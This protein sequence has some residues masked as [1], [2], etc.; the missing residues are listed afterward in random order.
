MKFKKLLCTAFLALLWCATSA[1]AY[2]PEDVEF[3]KKQAF[4]RTPVVRGVPNGTLEARRQY[5]TQTRNHLHDVLE[6][7]FEAYT[8]SSDFPYDVRTIPVLNRAYYS[9]DFHAGN[10]EDV[11]TDAI[12]LF[13]Y[14]IAQTP[15]IAPN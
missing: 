6:M 3:A 14:L 9:D 4:L 10:F 12:R 8:G 13:D 15:Q 5:Y 1:A 7:S 11:V 2:T